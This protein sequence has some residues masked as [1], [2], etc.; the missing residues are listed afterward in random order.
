LTS[1]IPPY[2]PALFPLFR[3]SSSSLISHNNSTP[4]PSP[5]PSFPL[6]HQPTRSV[7]SLSRPLLALLQSHHHPPHF[8]PLQS[9]FAA[10]QAKGT[11]SR[12]LTLLKPPLTPENLPGRPHL[13]RHRLRYR[14][15]RSVG[16]SGV[17]WTGET[18]RGGLEEVGQGVG[19]AGDCALSS[20]SLFSLVADLF[21]VLFDAMTAGPHPH[22]GR[23]LLP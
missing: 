1:P 3:L 20:Y 9:L 19:V 2:K 22:L 4:N 23:A 10:K 5:C 18:A 12:S 11:S 16:R 7:S 8:L 15:G 17:L 14:T 21:F 13:R 6:S